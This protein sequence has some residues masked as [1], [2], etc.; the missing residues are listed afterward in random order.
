M[1]QS[2]GESEEMRSQS[3]IESKSPPDVQRLNM[4]QK[5]NGQKNIVPMILV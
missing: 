3:S 4:Q 5:T 2:E 1:I